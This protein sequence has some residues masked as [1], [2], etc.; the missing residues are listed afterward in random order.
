SGTVG[1]EKSI[2][3]ALTM[4]EQDFVAH[5][6]SRLDVYPAYYVHMGVRNAA[7]PEPLDLR[8]PVRADA[9]ELSARLSAGEWVVDLRSRKAYVV[10]HLAGTVSLGL[11][12]PL[13]TWLGWMIDWGAPVT[14][15]GE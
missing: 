10:S 11:D 14:L 7:G 9:E 1:E 2:N 13:A 5:T 4:A 8:M 12:G 15:V 3:P 6:L